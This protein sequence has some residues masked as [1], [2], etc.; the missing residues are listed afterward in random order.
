MI[1]IMPALL[2]RNIMIK[3]DI[4]IRFLDHHAQLQ[5]FS[6]KQHTAPGKEGMKG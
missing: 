6:F 3:A 1:Y 5:Y 2:W 4:Y